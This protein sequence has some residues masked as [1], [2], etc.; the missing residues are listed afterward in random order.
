MA[1]RRRDEESSHALPSP[2]LGL[3]PVF[4]RARAG[5]DLTPTT[6]DLST[7]QPT[8]QPPKRLRFLLL[9]LPHVSRQSTTSAWAA[10]RSLGRA[11]KPSHGSAMNSSRSAP[12]LGRSPGC[13]PPSWPRRA[14][15][16]HLTHFIDSPLSAHTARSRTADQGPSRARQ[17]AGQRPPRSTRLSTR[18]RR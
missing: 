4:S 6:D 13:R 8:D 3:R 16:V 12:P 7:C 10:L 18:S 2:E 14:S 9:F 5:L 15:A 17:S 11:D 1:G